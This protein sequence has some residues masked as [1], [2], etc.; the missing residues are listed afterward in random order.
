ML[1]AVNKAAAAAYAR[2]AQFAAMDMVSLVA[3]V[4]GKPA[5]TL[6][7]SMGRDQLV[8][9]ELAI[10]EQLA[11]M[12]RISVGC[13]GGGWG[14]TA[15]CVPCIASALSVPPVR[16]DTRSEGRHG[17]QWRHVALPTRVLHCV[18]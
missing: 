5:A 11:S 3:E 14:A 7:E 12:L 6:E 8:M 10:L 2:V 16:L 9:T 15:R 17:V 4:T 1:A 18:G 13:L